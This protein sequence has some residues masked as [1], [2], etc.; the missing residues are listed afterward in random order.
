VQA[1]GRQISPP[2]PGLLLGWIAAHIDDRLIIALTHAED[3]AGAILPAV[4]S[5][6]LKLA[7]QLP[8]SW[9]A[10]GENQPPQSTLTLAASASPYDFG[11]RLDIAVHYACRANTNQ[12]PY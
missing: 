9:I 6:K 5:T 8:L 7:D 12:F 10:A 11:M 2:W 1:I 4:K 3:H